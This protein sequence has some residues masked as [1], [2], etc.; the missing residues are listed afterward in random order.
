ML[1]CLT[2]CGSSF[3]QLEEGKVK[4]GAN[5]HAETKGNKSEDRNKDLEISI[6]DASIE[7]QTQL[8]FTAGIGSMDYSPVSL[9]DS[10]GQGH[11]L[12]A[13]E[14]FLNRIQNED[15]L[16]GPSWRFQNYD[17]PVGRKRTKS[18]PCSRQPTKMVITVKPVHNTFQRTQLLVF[19]V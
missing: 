4:T 6:L 10:D 19:V 2:K 13:K 3:V 8:N 17:T 12:S 14:E 1:I 18:K 16:E 11:Y 5:A 7:N 15:P 9:N